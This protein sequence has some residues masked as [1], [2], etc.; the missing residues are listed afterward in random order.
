MHLAGIVELL[1]RSQIRISGQRA[2]IVG[3]SNIVGKPMAQLLLRRDATVTICHS[4][5]TDLAHITREA[6]ILVAAIGRPAF[7]RREHIKPGAAVIDVGMNRVM[8][9]NEACALFGEDAERRMKIIEQKGSTLIGDVHPAEAAA[10]AGWLTPVPGGVGPLTVAML[11]KN[12]LAA[13]LI[14]PKNICFLT[15]CPC[16]SLFQRKD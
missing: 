5:T 2:V 13:A 9:I 14:R 1:E 11:M 12:T 15:D 3:R 6:D 8:N 16:S 7:I 4:R 10:V